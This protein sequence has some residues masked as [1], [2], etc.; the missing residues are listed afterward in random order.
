MTWYQLLRTDVARITGRLPSRLGM[1]K[2]LIHPSLHAI[3]LY[4]IGHACHDRGLSPLAKA[5]QA[6]SIM[7]TGCDIHPAVEIGEGLSIGHT[8]GVVVGPEARIGPRVTLMQN[9][10][11]GRLSPKVAGMPTIGADVAIGAGAVLLG[12]IH[13]GDGSGIGA[14]ALV[15]E[16]VPPRS[17]VAAAPA[18]VIKIDGVRQQAPDDR[19]IAELEEVVERLGREHE[20][21]KQHVAAMQQRLLAPT[22]AVANKSVTLHEE[23]HS[24]FSL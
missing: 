23:T 22:E 8:S 13:I 1:L 20:T 21:L 10:T 9:I 17:R 16:S 24:R 14:N 18:R 12:P 7:L 11:L 6:L 2:V 5:C 4:R 3:A 19:R 15:I